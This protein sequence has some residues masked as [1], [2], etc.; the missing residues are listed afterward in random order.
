MDRA[1]R[2]L[3]GEEGLVAADARFPDGLLRVDPL[4]HPIDGDGADPARGFQ[5]AG[6]P[7]IG[8]LRGREPGTL[9]DIPGLTTRAPDR[10]ADVAGFLGENA[11]T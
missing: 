9:G 4:D 8:R 10:R 5:L 7:R 1:G 11:I 2:P 3:C 6:E